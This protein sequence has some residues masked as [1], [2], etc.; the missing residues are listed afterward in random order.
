MGAARPCCDS[1]RAGGRHDPPV[2]KYGGA[3]GRKQQI[4]AEIQEPRLSVPMLAQRYTPTPA[5]CSSG[6]SCFASPSVPPGRAGSCR[7]WSRGHPTRRHL[8]HRRARRR[9]PAQAAI[10]Q[11]LRPVRLVAIA[12]APEGALGHAQYLRRCRLTRNTATGASV[13]LFELHQSQPLCLLRPT[14]PNPPWPGSF[15]NS[16]DHLLH[17]P[18]IS[19]VSDSLTPPLLTAAR[20]LLHFA[21]RSNA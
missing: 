1:F 6:V 18:D 15:L 4:V 3:G 9:D 8:V 16:T 12:P 11:T 2:P 7:L 5:R 17:G 14:H 19:H 10:V 21:G 20:P 13:N